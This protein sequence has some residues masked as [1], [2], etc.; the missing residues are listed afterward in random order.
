[1]RSSVLE[2][3]A[4]PYEWHCFISYTTREKE[5]RLVKP[6]IDEFIG[7]LQQ[8]GVTF[9]PVFYDGWYLRRPHYEFSELAEKLRDGINGSAFTLA[10]LS[11]GYMS[12]DWCIYEWSTTEEIHK[13]REYPAQE[14]SILP[15]CWKQFVGKRRREPD[16]S[17]PNLL[18]RRYLDISGAFPS[19]LNSNWLSLEAI[20]SA[21][22]DSVFTTL[23]FLNQWYP[24]ENWNLN[25]WLRKDIFERS[26][27]L[28][29]KLFET[30]N[31]D[32][33]T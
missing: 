23:N 14:Y 8:Q 19:E 32:I 9:C 15:Q 2:K 13:R 11:P 24:R 7:I 31:L 6:F 27:K 33:Y 25:D 20:A 10:F 29:R 12:S 26:G 18:Y 17:E 21:L 22:E 1:M 16:H 3:S 5:V 4:S 28:L 30:N